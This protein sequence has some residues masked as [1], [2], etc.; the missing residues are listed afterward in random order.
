LPL[1]SQSSS[2]SAT[3]P[4]SVACA[5]NASTWA[6]RLTAR[7]LTEGRTP[8]RGS[9]GVSG[10]CTVG[11]VG[12][13]GLIDT[14]TWICIS[15]YGFSS[16]IRAHFYDP[17]LRAND[18]IP[19][20]TVNSFG[21]WHL[22]LDTRA[23]FFASL[24]PPPLLPPRYIH[25]ANGLL[26]LDTCA[27]LLYHSRHTRQLASRSGQP[28]FAEWHP[29]TACL[30]TFPPTRPSRNVSS[31]SSIHNQLLFPSLHPTFFT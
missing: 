27:S 10:S 26:D 25:S 22:D 3:S 12:S 30:R 28:H 5:S 9:S 8:R 7:T 31:A 16:R 21:N 29:S 1:P 14:V 13:E 18:F 23:I 11:Y 20:P 2:L 6:I 4:R 17:R 19:S 24:F 15:A